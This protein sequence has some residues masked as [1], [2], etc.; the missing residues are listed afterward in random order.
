MKVRRNLLR[1]VTKRFLFDARNHSLF[2]STKQAMF[3]NYMTQQVDKIESAQE[4]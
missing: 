1:Q 2:S 3:H 4:T